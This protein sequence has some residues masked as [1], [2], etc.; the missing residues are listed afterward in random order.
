MSVPTGSPEPG[1]VPG[2][3]G[4]S[5]S[6]CFMTV[7][8]N[9]VVPR[10]CP[11]QPALIGGDLGLPPPPMPDP[12]EHLFRQGPGARGNSLSFS[13]LIPRARPHGLLRTSSHSWVPT[14]PWNAVLWGG[15][16][17]FKALCLTTRLAGC[18]S[19]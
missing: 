9:P 16:L 13:G 14:S 18:L 8:P 6:I 2:T 5:L 15:P 10:S 11:G 7:L 19:I 12:R 3:S 17:L 4:L 1:P